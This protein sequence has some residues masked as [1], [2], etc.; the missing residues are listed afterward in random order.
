MKDKN[1]N[2]ILSRKVML[3]SISNIINYFSMD[4]NR[5]LSEDEKDIFMGNFENFKSVTDNMKKF[6]LYLKGQK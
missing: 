1:G 2:E 3:E 5:Q 6:Y 4:I